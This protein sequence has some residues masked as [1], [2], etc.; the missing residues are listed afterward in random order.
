MFAIDESS[1]TLLNAD[2]RVIGIGGGGG[3]AVETMIQSGVQ[4]VKFIAVNTDAQALSSNS[5]ETKIQLGAK[6]TKGLGAGANP[7]IG[8]RAAIE[9][10]E[11]IITHLNGAD[12]VFITAG[13]GGGTGT[14]GVPVVAEASRE[15]GAL[16]VGVVTTPFLFEGKRRKSHAEKGLAELRSHVDTLIIIP[17]EKLLSVVDDDTPLLNTFKK[18]DDILLQAVR[19]IADLIS[20]KGLINLDF[21]DVKTIMTNKGMALMGIGTAGGKDRARQ[22]VTRAVSSPLL[23][24]VSIQGAT[25]VIVNITAGSDL[26]LKEVNIASS[27][28]TSAVDPEAD[29]IV[30][31]VI[32]KNMED[33]LSVT[34]IATGFNDG[35]EISLPLTGGARKP[36]AD[37]DKTPLTTQDLSGADSV[38]AEKSGSGKQ[39]TI[40]EVSKSEQTIIPEMSKSEQTTVPDKKSAIQKSPAEDSRPSDEDSVTKEKGASSSDGTSKTSEK[41]NTAL[42]RDILLTK[43]KEYAEQAKNPVKKKKESIFPK[44]MAMDWREDSP[45]EDGDAS[46]SSPFEKDMDFSDEDLR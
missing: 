6:L 24:D 14:G 21:A 29:I 34:V 45:A 43:A 2:I 20:L 23:N 42:A 46:L 41:E 8:R 19:G 31:A 5:A 25:G 37:L 32:D 36:S 38:L 28:I 4:G 10:Y 39:T 12:M 3:N 16:T 17:N 35:P 33:R 9:S 27:L 40:P 44:Q 13:M 1:D 15:L 18:T 26:S 11:E 7:E 22:A 30:G